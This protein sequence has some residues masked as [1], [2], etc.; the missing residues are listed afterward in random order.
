MLGAEKE[1]INT[2][3]AAGQ[4]KIV[5]W[6]MLDLGDNST[7]AAAASACAGEQSVAAYWRMHDL[8][9]EQQRELYRAERDYFVDTAVSLGLDRSPFESCYDGGAAHAQMVQLDEARRAANVFSRPTIDVAGERILGSQRFAVFEQAI[10][11]AL[12]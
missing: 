9:F 1:I 6:P 2:F 5:F 11:A 10:Q 12:P 7:N 8:L 4:V 3:V